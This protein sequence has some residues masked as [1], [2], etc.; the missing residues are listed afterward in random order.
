M[1][2]TPQYCSKIY[3]HLFDVFHGKE[4]PALAGSAD[5][6]SVRV[7]ALGEV[8]VVAALAGWAYLRVALIQEHAVQ[9]L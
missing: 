9:A 6:L 3:T 8:L 1:R 7:L 2:R 4:T 5:D